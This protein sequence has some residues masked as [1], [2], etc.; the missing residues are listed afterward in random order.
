MRA[1]KGYGLK[2]M[3]LGTSRTSAKIV[4]TTRRL[5]ND[6]VLLINRES[7]PGYYFA[8]GKYLTY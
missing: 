4:A 5:D 3:E 6:F 1:E 8:C 7:Y 2:F